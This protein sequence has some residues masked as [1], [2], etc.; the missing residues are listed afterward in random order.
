MCLPLSPATLMPISTLSWEGTGV[1][2]GQGGAAAFYCQLCLSYQSQT[3]PLP[4][5]PSP[6]PFAGTA[7]P[8]GAARTRLT[9][10]AEVWGQPNA[11][12]AQ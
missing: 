3:Y 6:V 2:A 8:H 10:R 1:R 12:S 7:P 4:P 5:P 9:D 11:L